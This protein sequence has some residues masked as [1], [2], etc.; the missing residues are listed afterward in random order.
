VLRSMGHEHGWY[1]GQA[2]LPKD[3]RTL[4]PDDLQEVLDRVSAGIAEEASSGMLLDR[5]LFNEYL[6][7][8]K[9][10][11]GDEGPAAYLAEVLE[12]ERGVA[13]IAEAY[14]SRSSTALDGWVAEYMRRRDGGLRIH[15][16]ED[17]GLLEDALDKA[18]RLLVEQPGWLDG[19]HRWLLEAFVRQ[20]ESETE[21]AE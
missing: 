19:D 14:A 6:Y 13:R 2:S 3:Y 12:Q 18:R 4:Y 20:Y 11:E 10:A 17:F 1:R 5:E 16:L 9:Y 15:L 7:L 21:R 8:W